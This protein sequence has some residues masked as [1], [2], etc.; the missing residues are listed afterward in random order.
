M[1][2]KKEQKLTDG[3]IWHKANGTMTNRD[4]NSVHKSKPTTN[5]SQDILHNSDSLLDYS[6]L[7]TVKKSQI[8]PEDA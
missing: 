2:N 1:V 3:T 4:V 6:E 5:I 7:S 8:F